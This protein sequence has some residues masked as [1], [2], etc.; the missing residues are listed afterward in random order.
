MFSF[1][2]RSA[3]PV[4]RPRRSLSSVTAMVGANTSLDAPGACFIYSKPSLQNNAFN[5]SRGRK[6]SSSRTVSPDTKMDLFVSCLPGLENVLS[7]ELKALRIPHSP[8]IAG[9]NLRGA[10]LEQVLQ[11]HLYLGTASHVLLRCGK[12]F[13]ARSFAELRRKVAKTPWNKWL[14]KDACIVEIRVSASKSKLYH[15]GAIA[16][17]IR[18]AIDESLGREASDYDDNSEAIVADTAVK[19]TVRIIKDVVQISIDTSGSPLHE[20]GYRLE[21][22]KAPLREDIAFAMLF[23]SGWKP[24]YNDSDCPDLKYNGLLDPFCGS[25]T[26]LI[27]AASMLTLL[28]PGRLRPAPLG[29]TPFFNKEGWNTLKEEPS[30]ISL[31]S[32]SDVLIF[33]SD[34]DGGAVAATASNAERAGVGDVITVCKAAVAS[35]PWLEDPSVAPDAPLVLTN[36]PFGKRIKGKGATNE[37]LPLYQ[38]FGDRVAR[39]GDTKPATDATVLAHDVNLAR[40]MGLPLKVLF[41]THHGGIE[42]SA[43]STLSGK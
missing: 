11:C 35:N 31:E 38:T 41:S 7:S 2:V 42:V 4:F 6:L 3:R 8:S 37:L 34:R 29:G 19:L 30:T 20:R 5:I 26:I 43:M 28:P 15:T 21:T 14:A 12:P 9:A 27:E 22:A 40:R 10:S 18:K 25:G 17:R 16:E 24:R 32:N 36:P 39:L 23:L 13:R 33:G 1:A